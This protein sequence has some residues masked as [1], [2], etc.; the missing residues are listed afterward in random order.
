[1]QK[2]EHLITQLTEEL[3]S[4]KQIPNVN[5]LAIAWFSLSIVYVILLVNLL[6]PIRPGALDQL[7][8]SPR[9]LLEMLLGITAIGWLSLQAFRDSVP[10][11]LSRRFMV[12]SIIL[13]ILWQMQY[14]IGFVSPALEPSTLGK[15]NLCLY[16][17]IFY[18]L[19]PIYIAWL[20]VRRFY[21]LHPMRTAVSL[22]LASGM[23]PALYMQ[24][25]CMYDPSHTL[26]FHMAP[27]FLMIIIGV[28]IAWYWQPSN[29]NSNT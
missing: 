3:T 11:M 21:L 9:F 15:R 8:S 22:S 1:M 29:T 23:M 12:G 6:G 2:R 25:A 10:G 5:L 17:T 24:I 27:G 14:V 20:L 13:M 26:N 28:S 16:E 19:P 4:V 7:M 18:S